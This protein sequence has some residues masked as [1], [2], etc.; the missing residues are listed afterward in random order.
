MTAQQTNL[1]RSVVEGASHLQRAQYRDPVSGRR[2]V[3]PLSGDELTRF[4][5]AWSKGPVACI[6]AMNRALALVDE[7]RR[8]T[9]YV[10]AAFDLELLMDRR[11]KTSD[12]ERD[13]VGVPSY[14][15]D[16]YTDLGIHTS[17][18]RAPRRQKILVDKERLRPDLVC[19]RRRAL[20]ELGRWEARAVELECVLRGLAQSLRESAGYDEASPQGRV[21]DTTVRLSESIA[22]RSV[23]CR[24]LAILFQLRLQ[25]AG[26]GSRLMKGKLQLYS[27][28]LKHAW[29]VVQEGE[30]FALVDAAF[31]ED[32]VPF[33][34]VGNGPAEVYNRAAEMSRIY[35]PSPDSFHRY[36]I[37]A[38]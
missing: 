8:L 17:L 25:E 20:S 12:V 29:N 22:E 1:V 3:E 7:P 15:T 2:A 34:L 9:R 4:S 16:G 19:T 10:E 27:L 37:R 23:S 14:L 18:D 13:L 38:A 33:V 6:R 31:G 36:Q 30:L 28:K 26:L 35:S 32:D 24:H 5:S 21:R 11:S